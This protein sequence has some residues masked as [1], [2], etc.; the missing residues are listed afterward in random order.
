MDEMHAALDR[1]E[2]RIDDQTARIDALYELLEQRGM[3]PPTV[4]AAR[5]GS[6][7]DDASEA[8][9]RSFVWK[10]KPRPTR[11]RATRLRVGNATGV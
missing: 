1:L 6:L 2:T 11:R 4:A 9:D 5:G 7:F 3:L 10:Q 8:R